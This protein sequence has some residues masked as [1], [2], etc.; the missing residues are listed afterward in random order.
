[1]PKIFKNKTYKF[2]VKNFSFGSLNQDALIELFRDGRVA[3]HF[4]EPML[5]HWFPELQHVKGCKDY[6]HIDSKKQKY[7]AKNFTPSGGLKFMPSNQLGSGRKFCYETT[8]KHAKELVY[9]CC[10]IVDF[11]KIRVIFRDGEKLLEEYPNATI[12][13]T[14]RGDLFRD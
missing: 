11:P 13:K 2:V 4:I 14:K 8:R 5:T 10:D 3:S 9:I 12:S 7:D 1:M 6:D